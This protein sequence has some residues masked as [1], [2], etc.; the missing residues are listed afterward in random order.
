MN[1][2]F[3]RQCFI[4]IYS[5]YNSLFI[6]WK[7]QVKTSLQRQVETSNWLTSI[8]ITYYAAY[9]VHVNVA[10][11]V[12]S[13]RRFRM[14]PEMQKLYCNKVC[15][16]PEENKNKQDQH[17]YKIVV[18]NQAKVTKINIALASLM[19]GW[20]EGPSLMFRSHLEMRVKRR[21]IS[22]V[23]LGWWIIVFFS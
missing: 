13:W 11:I 14:N 1:V 17:I 20:I 4:R 2:H 12:R 18:G 9:L 10:N 19:C 3:M 22:E 16:A 23:L 7:A 21:K 8:L 6:T 5:K 15:I